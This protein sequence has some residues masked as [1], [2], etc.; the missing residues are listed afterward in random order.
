MKKAFRKK[1]TLSGLFV[2]SLVYFLFFIPAN[3]TGTKDP[4]MLIISGLDDL[5]GLGIYPSDEHAQYQALQRMTARQGSLRETVNNFIVHRYWQFGYPFFVL[6]AMTVLPVKAM[7]TVF[8]SINYTT[9]SMLALRQVGILFTVIA[10]LILVYMWTQY[11]DFFRSVFL[12]IFLATIPEVFGNSFWWHPDTLTTL[13]VVLTMF[14]L[15]KDNL[16]F[17]RW[18]YWAA[19]FCGLATGTKI[20]GLYFFAAVAFY[21]VLG[22]SKQRASVYAQIGRGAAFFAVMAATIFVTNP[23]LAVPHYSRDILQSLAEHK[24]LNEFGGVFNGPFALRGAKGPV[25][26]YVESLSHCFGYWWLL[27]IGFFLCILSIVRDNRK[28]LLATIILAWSVPLG[29][30]IMFFVANKSGRYFLP[31]LLPLLSCIGAPIV[32][33]SRKR[34]LKKNI[35]HVALAG[36][37][38][39]AGFQLWSYVKTNTDTYV[40]VLKREIDNPAIEFYNKLAAC[41]FSRLPRGAS[42]TVL[43]QSFLYMPPLQ[44]VNRVCIELYGPMAHRAIEYAQP[45]LILF[46]KLY[47]EKFTDP[48]TIADTFDPERVKSCA[49]IFRMAKTNSIPGYYKLLETEHFVA[50]VEN[51]GGM[52]SLCESMGR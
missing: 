37:L 21:L 35:A 43:Q 45:D 24:K 48:V 19:F 36:L 46:Q 32:W 34:G 52:S 12:F 41:F 23:L 7:C 6:S 26:W 49:K 27:L 47:I 13:W 42:V 29:L 3:L 17:G 14:A 11:E 28:R 4:N 25:A 22:I 39:A 44:N 20:I 5:N 8:S 18:F 31:V 50:F 2:L 38:L 40:Y 33:E 15:Y 9:A 16:C 51:S 30:Y 10:I 1:L